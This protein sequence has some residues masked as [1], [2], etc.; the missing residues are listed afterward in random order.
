MVFGSKD[1]ALRKNCGDIVLQ[2]RI[3]MSLLVSTSKDI[4]E[5]ASKFFWNTKGSVE[6]F[7]GINPRQVIE[8]T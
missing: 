6:E 4:L 8:R 5:A 1:I 2:L 7:P 3:K